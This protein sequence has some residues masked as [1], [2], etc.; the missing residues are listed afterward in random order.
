MSG[1]HFTSDRRPQFLG[2]PPT[3]V[4]L[5]KLVEA[6]ILTHCASPIL[7]PPLIL[8]HDKNP[9]PAIVMVDQMSMDVHLR[10][11]WLGDNEQAVAPNATKVGTLSDMASAF[12]RPM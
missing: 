9:T 12:A 10:A 4:T 7:N 5:L 3:C 11:F 1:V 2:Q 6:E 8:C